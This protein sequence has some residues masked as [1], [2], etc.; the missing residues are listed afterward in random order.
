MSQTQTINK[1]FSDFLT[2]CLTDKTNIEQILYKN[3]NISPIHKEGA[4]CVLAYTKC[5]V[6]AESKNRYESY[7]MI[8]IHGFPKWANG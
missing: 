3:P 5:I 7:D 4:D 6:S 8:L 1:Y 2:M